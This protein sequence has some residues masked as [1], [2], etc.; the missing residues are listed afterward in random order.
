M[1]DG[2]IPAPGEQR[3]SKAEY[4][5]KV[6]KEKKA[7]FQ[8]ADATAR[9]AVLNGEAMKALLDTQSRMNLYS[10]NNVLLIHAQCPRASCIRTYDEWQKRFVAVDKG[11]RAISILEP[12][13]YEK[14]DGTKATGFNIKRFF[15]VSQTSR[16]TPS[17]TANRDPEKL[18][19]TLIDI[20]RV[21][22]SL[23]E[24]IPYPGLAAFYDNDTETIYV[25]KAYGNSEVTFQH[26][27]QEMAHAEFSL[28]QD[29]YTYG[30]NEYGY[31]ATCIA[32]MICRKFGVSC[33]TLNVEN[34]PEIWRSYDVKQIKEQLNGMREIFNDI[35]G[36]L[37]KEYMKQPGKDLD[38]EK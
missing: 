33:D 21:R 22:V 16:Q 11:A 17:P 1:T 29:K 23:T 8:L 9:A 14:Q 28:K 3:Y 38:I 2:F 13:R 5:E 18:I 26:L 34:V 6:T 35:C 12:F 20:S 27:A 25:V 31:R 4:I 37:S 7:L 30:R 10:V 32:Y 19:A 24:N 36:R 15:D